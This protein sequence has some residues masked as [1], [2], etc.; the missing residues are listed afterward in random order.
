MCDYKLRNFLLNFQRALQYLVLHLIT[1]TKRILACVISAHPRIGTT[2]VAQFSW[3]KN[4][5]SLITHAVDS[6]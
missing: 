5:V 1:D 6:I 2:D 3:Y 4:C